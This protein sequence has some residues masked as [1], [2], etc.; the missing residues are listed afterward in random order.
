MRA[1]TFTHM[2][3]TRRVAMRELLRC[4][5]TLRAIARACYAAYGCHSRKVRSI[6]AARTRADARLMP[7]YA[8]FITRAQ[9]M[10]VVT[11]ERYAAMLARR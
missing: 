3:L 6:R 4:H 5:V 1:A 9:F 7:R 10:R 8:R 11:Q 2:M